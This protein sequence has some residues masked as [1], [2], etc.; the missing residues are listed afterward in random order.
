MAL[1]ELKYRAEVV[2]TTEQQQF[3]L[4]NISFSHLQMKKTYTGLDQHMG[5]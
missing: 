4:L 5:E 2:W 1:E 3:A